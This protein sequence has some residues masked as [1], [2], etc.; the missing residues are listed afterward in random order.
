M[1][2]QDKVVLILCSMMQ[3]L[4]QCYTVCSIQCYTIKFLGSVPSGGSLISFALCG[5]GTLGMPSGFGVFRGAETLEICPVRCQPE[6]EW[7]RD[8]GGKRLSGLKERNL[9]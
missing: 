2:K 3:C 9:R 1:V 8:L 4:Q 7:R 6:G 5:K